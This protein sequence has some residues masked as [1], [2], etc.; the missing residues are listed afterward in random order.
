MENVQT[1]EKRSCPTTC[2]CYLHLILV[3]V[4]VVSLV[5]WRPLLPSYIFRYAKF[6]ASEV[7]NDRR[8][9]SDNDLQLA[10]KEWRFYQI[11]SRFGQDWCKIKNVEPRGNVTWLTTMVNDEFIVPALVLGYSIRKFS[12][13]KNMIA[14]ISADVS[15]GAVKALQSIGWE[16]RLVEEMDCGRLDAK[17]GGD[18]NSG[19]FGKPRGYRI[20][21]THTRFHAWN[22]TEYYIC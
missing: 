9:F 8:R 2:I 15:E 1:K 5:I 16:T 13:Q 19:F 6:I 11:E 17:I 10:D 22:Y 14:F 4:I 18:R 3:L 21:G 12:C 7:S 20:R